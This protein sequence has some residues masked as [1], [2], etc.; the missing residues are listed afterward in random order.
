MILTGR[1]SADVRPSVA[2]GEMVPLSWIGDDRVPKDH[3][4]HVRG[5]V[6]RLARRH[7][8]GS[9]HVRYFGPPEPSGIHMIGDRFVDR[10]N[11]YWTAP[12]AGHVPLGV[13]PDDQPD[14]IG[15]HYGL[16]G[17]LVAHTIAHELHHLIDR[18]AG[19]VQDEAG[20]DRF[21][22]RYVLG[23]RGGCA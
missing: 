13:A 5:H 2:A 6:R 12:D 1:V 14:T 8:L 7:G 11:F 15:L 9:V 4:A 23:L 16:R 17:Q 18:R 3:R 22:A 21:A 20:C 10:G 19:V